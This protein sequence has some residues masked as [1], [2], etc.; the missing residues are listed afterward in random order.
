[1]SR[2]AWD[3]SLNKE[4]AG[5]EVD[6]SLNKLKNAWMPHFEGTEEGKNK[7]FNVGKGGEE[8]FVF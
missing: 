1:M 6:I 3:S 7:A 5:Q 4:K 8:A 2:K